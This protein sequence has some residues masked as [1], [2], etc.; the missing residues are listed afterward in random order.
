LIS[1][2]RKLS[3][4]QRHCRRFEDAPGAV[5][6]EDMRMLYLVYVRSAADY[7]ASAW[8]P[9]VSSSQMHKIEIAQ[10]AAARFITNCTAST[11]A[12][13]SLTEANLQPFAIH[14]GELAAVAYEKSLRLPPDNPR[15]AVVNY[16][17]SKRLKKGSRRT[18]ALDTIQGTSLASLP[19]EGFR[20][21]WPT[22]P[23]NVLSEAVFNPTL[24]SECTRMIQPNSSMT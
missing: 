4:E 1:S 22:A 21:V 20:V 16:E 9:L 12:D 18:A 19:R 11:P 13:S 8:A 14:A 5:I 7:C 23:W 24:V 17:A 15:N 3:P 2:R 10:Q 6:R